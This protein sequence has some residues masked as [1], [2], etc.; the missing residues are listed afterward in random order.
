MYDFFIIAVFAVVRAFYVA[1]AETS[2]FW[3]ITKIF[4][5]TFSPAEYGAVLAT[6]WIMRFITSCL[7]VAKLYK[8]KD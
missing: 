3:I 2:I 7:K 4:W 8:K 1:V 6:L 5:N